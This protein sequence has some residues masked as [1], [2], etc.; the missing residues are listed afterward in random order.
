MLVRELAALKVKFNYVSIV[1]NLQVVL[2]RSQKQNSISTIKF[3]PQIL[4]WLSFVYLVVI[5]NSTIKKVRL[6]ILYVK[7]NSKWLKQNG[8][9]S[10]IWLFIKH[11]SGRDI[12]LVVYI[13]TTADSFLFL[14]QR[15][16]Y[17]VGRTDTTQRISQVTGRKTLMIWEIRQVV[18]S[19]RST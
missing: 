7:S 15:I 11:V 4:S 19:V 14:H 2:D 9:G 8:C 13:W 10:R 17:H 18:L 5:I 16:V 1:G 3:N 6:N 12:V